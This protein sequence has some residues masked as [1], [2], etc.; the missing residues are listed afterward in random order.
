MKVIVIGA[1]VGG[2]ACALALTAAGHEVEVYEQGESLRATGNGMILW[3]N[4]TGILREL[5]V[6]LDGLGFP[7]GSIDSRTDD[8]FPLARIDVRGLS[9][10]YGAP[11][12]LVARGRLLARMAALLPAGQVGYGRRCVAIETREGAGLAV[13]VTFADG[14]TA[15][16]DALIGAD[17]HRSLVRQVLFGQEPA[18]YT[19]WA[20]WHGLTKAPAELVAGD[21]VRS[22]FAN[23]GVCGLH[24]VG[25]GY[26]HWVFETPWADGESVPGGGRSDAKVERLRALF[27]SWADPVPR[28]LESIEESDVSLFPHII[29][30]VPEGG[31]GGPV[32]LAG[33]AAHALPPR[34]AMGV[35]QALEDAWVLG[36]VLTTGRPAADALR[37]YEQVRRPRLDRLAARAR[38]LEGM[39]ASPAIRFLIWMARKGVVSPAGTGQLAVAR[40]SNYLNNDTPEVRR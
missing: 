19:G 30:K 28:L 1:G 21:G 32:T 25:D 31:G 22:F 18:A 14:G 15:S 7:M 5:G 40:S 39:N 29:H 11:T 26:L 23:G 16:A 27:G 20:S 12:L 34:A 13:T 36:R 4:G 6:S 37:A 38:R 35:N 8:G 2:V 3:P 9:E 24:P 10:R 17:G 33:D